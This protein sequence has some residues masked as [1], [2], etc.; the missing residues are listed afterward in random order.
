MMSNIFFMLGICSLVGY[1]F[2]LLVIRIDEGEFSKVYTTAALL[3]AGIILLL[4]LLAL[5]HS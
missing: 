3:T 5:N 1:V 2:I 4:F